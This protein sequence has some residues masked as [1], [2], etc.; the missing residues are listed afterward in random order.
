M[1]PA[2]T[3]EE[4]GIVEANKLAARFGTIFTTMPLT[5][6]PVAQ[7]YSIS[8][9]LSAEVRNMQDPKTIDRGAYDG[10]GHSRAE[11]LS[12]YLAGKIIHIPIQPIVEEDVLDGTLAAHHRAVILPGIDH[13]EANVVTAFEQFIIDGGAVLL[14]DESKVQ[15]DGRDEKIGVTASSSQYDLIERLW[16]EQNSRISEASRGERV[17][18][19]CRAVRAG[20]AR[21]ASEDGI[22][23]TMEC[24]QRTV[25]TS[26]QALGDVEYL[27]ATN[28]TPD[29][30]ST[31]LLAIK[32]ALATLSVADDGRPIYDA[33]RGKAASEFA[34]KD[35]GISATIRFGAGQIRAFANDPPN[36]GCTRSAP[37]S[38]GAIVATP[39]NPLHVEVTA[40]VTDTSGKILSGSIPLRVVL[41]DPLGVTR[42]D[43]FRDRQG[44]VPH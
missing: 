11:S 36:R 9:N 26:R 12:T 19:R 7:L 39:D 16:H 14:S 28:A 42:F 44:P 41:V 15:I 27:F 20:A 21:K 35:E 18:E 30:K 5:R 10:G 3:P 38:C 34:A 31:T 17:Y 25:V 8:Q 32:P 6:P 29:E 24:D 40:M 13:L 1:I 4:A 23:P 37:R 43:L 22:H 33:I 2:Q